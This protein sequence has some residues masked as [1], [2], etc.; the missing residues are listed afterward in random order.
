MS[1]SGTSRASIPT[2]VALPAANSSCGGGATTSRFLGSR[3]SPHPGPRPGPRPRARLALAGEP[4]GAGQAAAATAA[5]SFPSSFPDARIGAGRK[6]TSSS[7]FLKTLRLTFFGLWGIVCLTDCTV[8]V[9]QLVECQTV[10]LVAV[11][12][13]PIT[14][15]T[16][17]PCRRGPFRGTTV[18]RVRSS[19]G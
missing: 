14:H 4:S 18:T 6:K 5:Q 13:N 19:A 11:G 15:P 2:A 17:P 8:G 3:R 12:S 1:T 9:A 10:D 7:H 16:D